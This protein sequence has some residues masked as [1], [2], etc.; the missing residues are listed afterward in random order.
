MDKTSLG[1]NASTTLS[2]MDYES[3]L[4]NVSLVPLGMKATHES[5]RSA[6]DPWGEAEVPRVDEDNEAGEHR[7]AYEI[8]L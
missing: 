8:T 1:S 3:L 5:T 2:Y 6:D 4:V 7:K